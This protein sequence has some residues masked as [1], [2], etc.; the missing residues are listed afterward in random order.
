MICN[1]LKEMLLILGIIWDCVNCII[2][3]M[4]K[5]DWIYIFSLKLTPS[6]CLSQTFIH[7][8]QENSLLLYHVTLFSP[9]WVLPTTHLFTYHLSDIYAHFYFMN[10]NNKMTLLGKFFSRVINSKPRV[11]YFNVFISFNSLNIYNR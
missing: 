4:G 1:R 8:K 6:P 3:T 2:V 10:Y 11:N 5:F 9:L 7:L